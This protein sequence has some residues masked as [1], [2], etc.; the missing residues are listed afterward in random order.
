MKKVMFLMMTAAV[1]CFASCGNKTQGA[2]P[3]DN[4]STIVADSTIAASDVEAAIN[5]A[6]TKLAEQI[7]AK[8]ASKL[9]QAIAT[10]QAKVAEILAENP[11][12]AKEYVTQVQSFLKENADKIKAVA[13]NNTAIQAAV[14][15]LT[16][17]PADAIISGLK[18][19]LSGAQE[20]GDAANKAADDAVNEAKKAADDAANE[21]KKALGI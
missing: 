4:D 10:V 20:V 21:A 5:Q 1:I 15:A 9:Q 14:N 12:A 19:T 2:A 17:A 11:D 7:E 16:A 13:G 18:S 8:D 6:T 3:V